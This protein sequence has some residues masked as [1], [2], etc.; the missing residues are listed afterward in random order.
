MS[1]LTDIDIE[2][3]MDCLKEQG[4][5]YK[6]SKEELKKI[7]KQNT[8]KSVISKNINK[9]DKSDKDDEYNNNNKIDELNNSEEE[10]E[11]DISDINNMS[12]NKSFESNDDTEDN[13]INNKLENEIENNI[14]DLSPE[15]KEIKETPVKIVNL[16]LDI[17]NIE[18][19]INNSI[20]E[21]IKETLADQVDIDIDK[22]DR[23][24]LELDKLIEISN[25]KLKEALHKK[26]A[27][28]KK[29]TSISENLKNIRN[30]LEQNYSTILET[31]NK[32]SDEYMT[33]LG[34]I[35]N[36]LKKRIS[37]KDEYLK[38][39]QREYIKREREYNNNEVILKN[40][41]NP[42]K[43]FTVPP[44]N[45][46][47]I[48]QTTNRY[49]Y[50]HNKIMDRTKINK[51]PPPPQFQSY[52]QNDTILNHMQNNRYSNIDS[53]NWY[54][55]NYGQQNRYKSPHIDL[56]LLLHHV[57][58]HQIMVHYLIGSLRVSIHHY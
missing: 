51:P 56:F 43:R 39:T 16:E 15:N 28:K 53:E 25:A 44:L 1:D 7:L 46:D 45:L 40:N 32:I 37:E 12:E 54:Q 21:T 41:N 38:D 52:S 27:L 18:T 17:D 50:I 20:E 24:K 47:K 34:N 30:K 48:N 13:E 58:N 57:F 5:E 2:T 31:Q 22:E 26:D 14:S 3:I 42:N 6:L 36:N 49:D 4:Y 8:K 55:S 9:E 11:Y 23:H 29:Q 35:K 19:Q 33:K 10:M